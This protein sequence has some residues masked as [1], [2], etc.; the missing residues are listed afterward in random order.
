MGLLNHSTPESKISKLSKTTGM[1][2]PK[3]SGKKHKDDRAS[4]LA[5]MP[6]RAQKEGRHEVEALIIYTGGR[7]RWDTGSSG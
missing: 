7:R 1:R 2:G 3:Y 6:W 4:L 5:T